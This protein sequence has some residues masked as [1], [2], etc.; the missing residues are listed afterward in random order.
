[1]HGSGG[2]NIDMYCAQRHAVCSLERIENP[3][4]RHGSFVLFKVE[5]RV[6]WEN[7]KAMLTVRSAIL[8]GYQP[9]PN[10]DTVQ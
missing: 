2:L 3:V 9:K 1:M 8:V 4:R 6:T 10:K 7:I 5:A